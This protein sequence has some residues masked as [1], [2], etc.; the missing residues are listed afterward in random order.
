MQRTDFLRSPFFVS[1][2]P[3]FPAR[4]QTSIFGAGELNCRVRNGNGW[5][6]TAIS[7][8]LLSFEKESKQRKL[9]GTFLSLPSFSTI[10]YYIRFSR[11]SQAL[12]AWFCSG[13]ST[14]RAGT[15][16]SLVRLH[17][18]E[19]GTHWLRVSCSTNWAKGAYFLS[20]KKVCKESFHK[21]CFLKSQVVCT[22]KT[23]QCEV[24]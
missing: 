1:A 21:L 24:K 20:R 22:L 6:L 3:I 17:G 5:T 18:F 2:L 23:E 16:W 4:L 13:D 9:Q 15:R 10:S 8:N 7:T 19:P 11:R 12:F 14:G